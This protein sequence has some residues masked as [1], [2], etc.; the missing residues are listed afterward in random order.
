MSSSTIRR[1][2]GSPIRTNGRGDATHEWTDAASFA[3]L[4]P[5]ADGF[6]SYLKA[7][8]SV[9][10]EELLLDRASLLG[11]SVPD[12]GADTEVSLPSA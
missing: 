8:H 9:R 12:L 10:T 4:E 6:R 11:L 3:V 2:R 5:V 7:K 1:R